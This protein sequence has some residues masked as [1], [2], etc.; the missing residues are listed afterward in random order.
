MM[1]EK[2]MTYLKTQIHSEFKIE[3][4]TKSIPLQFQS[5]LR[6]VTSLLQLLISEAAIIWAFVVSDEK[7][8]SDHAVD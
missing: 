8:S 5:Q 2:Q 4:Q 3:V 7:Q 1:Q 6:I